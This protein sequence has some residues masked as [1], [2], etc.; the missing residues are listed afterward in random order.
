MKVETN[1]HILDLSNQVMGSRN[2]DPPTGSSPYFGW[3]DSFGRFTTVR[4]ENVI[5]LA[6]EGRSGRFLAVLNNGQQM[7]LPAE[8]GLRL[9]KRMGW[10]ETSA[11][12]QS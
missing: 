12:H 1:G 4:L 9:M 5:A 10:K 2:F 3:I 11:L 7:I 8:D 6:P